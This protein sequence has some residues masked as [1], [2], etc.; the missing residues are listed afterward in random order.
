MHTPDRRTSSRIAIIAALALTS[1]LLAP[2][3]AHATGTGAPTTDGPADYL[4]GATYFSGWH[5]GD[6]FHFE[7]KNGQDWRPDHPE[8]EPLYGWYDDTQAVMDAQIVD[9]STNGVD[10]FSFDWYAERPAIGDGGVLGQLH[11]GMD[12]FRTSPENHRMSYV[13][14]YI[15]GSA[16][17]ISSLKTAGMT[18]A[19]YETVR[20]AEWDLLTT[21]WVDLF[22]DPA[23]LKIDGKP[24][25]E[26]YDVQR[27]SSDFSTGAHP[28]WN[29]HQLAQ[30]P[31]ERAVQTA[32]IELLKDKA[33]AAGFDDVLIG[34]GL[35]Q[36]G[37]SGEYVNAHDYDGMYDWFSAYGWH[38]MKRVPDPDN[39][40]DNLIRDNHDYVW[41]SYA[42]YKNP[43]VDY[44][45][46]ITS[47]WDDIVNP[48]YNKW[49]IGKTPEAFG[50]Y[51]REAK[52]YVDAHPQTN[53][54]PGAEHRIVK[55]GSWNELF[56]GHSIVPTK[57]EG[58]AYVSQVAAVFGAPQL[59]TTVTVSA[60]DYSVT[61]GQTVEL[62][63][64]IASALAVTGA[65]WTLR[66]PATWPASDV[67]ATG[68]NPRTTIT[69]PD[70]VADGLLYNVSDHFPGAGDTMGNRQDLAVDYQYTAGGVQVSGTI[71]LPLTV[72][73]ALTSRLLTSSEDG[74]ATHVSAWLH[75][76]SHTPIAG[77][78]VADPV[79]GVT[80]GAFDGTIEL[81]PGER[82][83]TV[84][85]VAN[86]TVADQH[87]RFEFV[88]SGGTTDLGLALVT[89]VETP[90]FTVPALDGSVRSDG[91]VEVANTN[92]RIQV[93]NVY[94][95]AE[96]VNTE[97]RPVF[98]FP[99][100]QLEGDVV[101]VV[102]ELTEFEAGSP[103][104]L[105]AERISPTS[106]ITSA[107]FSAPA[108]DSTAFPIAGSPPSEG[109]VRRLDVTGWALAALAAGE[110]HLTVRVRMDAP[111]PGQTQYR[112]F[113]PTEHTPATMADAPQLKVV[114]A[115]QETVVVPTTPT[116]DG[117]VR[118]DAIIELANANG[119][120][121]LGNVARTDGTNTEYRALLTF[122][123]S[124]LAGE[125]IDRV[126]LALTE[127]EAGGSPSVVV[128]RLAPTSGLVLAQYG[129]AAIESKAFAMPGAPPAA[130]VERML[131]V[132]G[133]V[134]AAIAAGES[135]LTLRLRQDAPVAATTTYRAF[136]ANEATPADTGD[137][138]R[139]VAL[140]A[141]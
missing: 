50:N 93:G 97:Y 102:L 90:Y 31:T 124:T 46:L 60:D 54:E 10:F 128:E 98:S 37:F 34:G 59:D 68:T 53:L 118:S 35:Q 106:T 16:F 126:R 26:I 105:T 52:S 9:A 66:Y 86:S 129:A 45:P 113:R 112:T 3:A 81:A 28:D 91:L 7:Y 12:L 85:D 36:P 127:F 14:N 1:T 56:E 58:D 73:P 95:P 4:V 25:I 135:H 42:T 49:S 63:F 62:G 125:D 13:V 24:L 138:P 82:R 43:A 131:D 78:L 103:P 61:P 94:R 2:A 27:F 74:G 33:D 110:S 115:P 139:L 11:N 57:L 130:G 30:D 79:P 75:N 83:E 111:V 123:L 132:T 44:I 39:R 21:Q 117:N 69:V 107:A 104:A 116:T 51:L 137:A 64:D 55:I 15:N 80:L 38:D 76:Q 92:G 5:S 101:R 67:G 65:Q 32:A 122:D 119:R 109:V 71:P 140:V 89:P 114:A 70:D 23:Y 47:G 96:G 20:A 19:Q 133:W 29:P 48:Q 108:L 40:Y 17:S 87:V 99:L 6:N 41:D 120:L 77:E 18:Q 22:Q 88:Q 84:V 136:R 134:T 8:R 100:A 121:Q 141:G 72:V